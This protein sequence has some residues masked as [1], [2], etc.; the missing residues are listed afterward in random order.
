M[1]GDKSVVKGFMYR[2]YVKRILDV[3]LSGSALVVLFPVLLVIAVL[4]LVFHGKPVMY[5]SVRPG[6]GEKLF[7][8]YKFRTM[9]EERDEEGALLPEEQ[10]LTRFGRFLRRTSLDE[11]PQLFNILKGDMSIIGPRALLPKYLELYPA[12]YRKRHDVRPGFA[13]MKLKNDEKSWTWREQFEND[14]FYVEHLSFWLDVKMVFAVIRAV[15]DGNKT[16]VLGNRPEFDGKN[17]D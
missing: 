8:I 9:T 12:E 11:L 6:Y 3:V 14:I 7:P 4:E 10:R 17:L 16:R 1:L 13:C 5:H 2:K 15:F